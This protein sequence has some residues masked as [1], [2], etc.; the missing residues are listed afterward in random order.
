MDVGN[1]TSYGPVVSEGVVELKPGQNAGT[2]AVQLRLFQ[3]FDNG[4]D[5]VGLVS[6]AALAAGS[7]DY[8]LP[9]AYPTVNGQALVATTGG[10]MSWAALNGTFGDGYHY[11]ENTTLQTTTNNTYVEYMKLTTAALAAGT[12]AIGWS[13]IWNYSDSGDSIFY[14]VQ[15]DDSVN[16]I[17]PSNG[18][19]AVERPTNGAS[20]PRHVR[21]GFRNITLGAGVH[22]VDIDFKTADG[23][24]TARMYFGNIELWRVA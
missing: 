19:E 17:D 18:G 2:P 9:D 24:D 5:Y 12:Y 1:L 4:A 13:A 16:L 10:V 7:T 23:V 15:V 3:D 11:Q 21:S 6:P 14:R 8:V 20:V 22:T